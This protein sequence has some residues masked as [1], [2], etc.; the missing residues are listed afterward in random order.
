[1][2][3]R[4]R[5]FLACLALLAISG[6]GMQALLSTPELALYFT[7]L[8]LV[9]GLLLCGRYVGEE[10]I[11]ARRAA[12]VSAAPRRAPR[13]VRRPASSRPPASLLAPRAH[14][15]RGPPALLR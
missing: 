7:P 9:V 6:A 11:L 1:M 3:G 12:P 5:R 4:Q 13:S 2:A 15:E 14:L 10:R 8:L